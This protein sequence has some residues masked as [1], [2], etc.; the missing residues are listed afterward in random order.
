MYVRFYD[1]YQHLCTDCM[2]DIYISTLES[3]KICYLCVC[4]G[5]KQRKFFLNAVTRGGA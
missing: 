4:S 1:K 5:G 2:E 3:A